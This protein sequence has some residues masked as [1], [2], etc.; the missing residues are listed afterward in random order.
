MPKAMSDTPKPRSRLVCFLK[1]VFRPTLFLKATATTLV[2]AGAASLT[3]VIAVTLPVE[4]PSWQA[5]LPAPSISEE[6]AK[7]ALLRAEY[8][9]EA[10]VRPLLVRAGI[11]STTDL[12]VYDDKHGAPFSSGAVINALW[13]VHPFPEL[14]AGLLAALLDE[15]TAPGIRVRSFYLSGEFLSATA[16]AIAGKSDKRRI[17]RRDFPKGPLPK[18]VKWFTYFHYAQEKARR[19]K[20]NHGNDG[21][22]TFSEKYTLAK[23]ILPLVLV[24]LQ[25]EMIAQNAQASDKKGPDVQAIPPRDPKHRDALVM[26]LKRASAPVHKAVRLMLHKRANP[27]FFALAKDIITSRQGRFIDR[28]QAVSLIEKKPGLQP[29]EYLFWQQYK[30]DLDRIELRAAT[31]LASSWAH[32]INGR[33]PFITALTDELTARGSV[34]LGGQTGSGVTMT[35]VETFVPPSSL[36]GKL[37]MLAD[38]G[39]A[40]KNAPAYSLDRAYPVFEGRLFRHMAEQPLILPLN[41]TNAGDAALIAWYAEKGW[42]QNHTLLFSAVGTPMEVAQHWGSVHLIWGP[43][44]QAPAYLWPV[45]GVFMAGLLPHLKGKDA[46]RFLGPVTGLWF[47]RQTVDPSGWLDELYEARPEVMPAPLSAQRATLRSPLLERFQLGEAAIQLWAIPIYT[48]DMAT[49][50]LH[51][52]L[53]AKLDKAF[54]HNHRV[55][56]ARQLSEKTKDDEL[57]PLLVFS[58]VDSTVPLL[59]GWGLSRT[60]DVAFATELLWQHRADPVAKKRIREILSDVKQHPQERIHAVQR[61]LHLPE[62]KDG[63]RRPQ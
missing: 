26:Y 40:L 23:Q 6:Q 9:H 1:T 24:G 59:H 22:A 61:V 58:F 3:Y 37:Y 36:P 39:R 42:K 17:S 43:G 48:E 56:L 35:Q 21:R 62:P 10:A 16:E 4:S 52:N 5:A 53:W 31:S 45:N 7:I 30:R 60:E 55:G 32:R 46:T 19:V 27:G 2:L 34:E 41:P 29:A 63:K 57:P 54:R 20:D 50:I 25:Q 13:S 49:I 18:N 28:Y 12:T 47:G 15:S 38:G 51:Q 8:L 14:H 11:V 44:N 33:K